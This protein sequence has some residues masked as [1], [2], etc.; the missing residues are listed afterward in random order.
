MTAK[1]TIQ[2][3]TY[4]F[5]AYVVYPLLAGVG[6][7]LLSRAN[8]TGMMVAAA[9]LLSGVLFLS[10]F[11]GRYCRRCGERFV[12]RLMR[13][14]V[15]PVA[16]MMALGFRTTQLRIQYIAFVLVGMS[17]VMFSLA[18]QLSSPAQPTIDDK[19]A[20]DEDGRAQPL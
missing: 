7:L 3:R 2:D 6:A 1:S 14:L 19:D 20:K 16:V 18:W 17:A 9:V 13:L 11:L 8:S 12:P 4:R 5:G 10:A 15:M